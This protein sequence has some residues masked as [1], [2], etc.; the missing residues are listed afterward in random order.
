MHR[1]LVALAVAGLLHGPAQARSKAAQY[2]V[3]EL[4]RE[5]CDGPGTF[6]ASEIVERDLTGDGAADLILDLHGIACAGGG[7]ASDCGP[8]ACNANIYV[9]EKGLLRL[10][11][12][13]F[14]VGF[15]IRPGNPPPIELTDRNF[16][17]YTIRWN[18][19]GFR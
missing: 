9:R 16:D 7:I 14:S 11:A 15:E 1:I 3:D 18:G 12:E 19:S 13:E 6:K 10:K 17:K 2:L 4:I 8:A 5:N